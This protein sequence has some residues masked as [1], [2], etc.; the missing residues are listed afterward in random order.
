MNPKL[1]KG[2]VMEHPGHK[3]RGFIQDSGFGLRE[4]GSV[5]LEAM[6]LLCA[7]MTCTEVPLGAQGSG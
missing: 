6:T 7:E 3:H 2:G 5:G 4:R 1:K